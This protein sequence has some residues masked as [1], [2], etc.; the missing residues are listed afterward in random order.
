MTP[1]QPVITEAMRLMDHA[2]DVVSQGRTLAQKCF[3]DQGLPEHARAVM[4]SDSPPN[5]GESSPTSHSSSVRREGLSAVDKLVIGMIM[6]GCV[7]LGWGLLRS[8]LHELAQTAA[9]PASPPPY[10]TEVTNM[11]WM[12]ATLSTA[13]MIQLAKGQQ[14]SDVSSDEREGVTPEDYRALEKLGTV[15]V[16]DREGRPEIR[17]Q[18]LSGAVC[19]ALVKDIYQS[20]STHGVVVTVDG[21]NTG[22]S[23]AGSNHDIVLT[24]HL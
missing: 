16:V 12:A 15:T 19:H 11:R 9:Q 24:P 4:K 2:D 1:R 17:W 3:E 7:M 6:C 23:C 14:P 5:E 21:Q 18:H 13:D 8:G 10:A 20:A 22:V